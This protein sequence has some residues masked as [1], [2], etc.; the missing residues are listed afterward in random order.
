[1]T[2]QEWLACSD[3]APMLEFLRGKA[4]DRKLRLFACACCRCIWHLL[5]DRRSRKAVE[6]SERFAD[7][8]I[9]LE[10]LQF[11]RGDARWAANV[12]SR[13]SDDS[14]GVKWIVAHLTEPDVYRVLFAV[15]PASYLG[16]REIQYTLQ[17]TLLR[18]VFGNP[19]RPITP[20]PHWLT[21]NVVSLAQAIYDD[22]AFDRMPEL[23][24][25]LHEAGCRNDEILSHCRGPGPHVRGCWGVDIIIGKK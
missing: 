5:P 10:K 4:S 9:T 23:A 1:M 21:P 22:R 6:A 20:N 25:A 15:W 16:G 8:L 24:D 3:P 19:F 18:D 17:C 11:V 13:K 7:G 12:A 2:E 14:E